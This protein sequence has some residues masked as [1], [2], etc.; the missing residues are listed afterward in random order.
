MLVGKTRR[1]SDNRAPKREIQTSVRRKG[2]TRDRVSTVPTVADG[3]SGVWLEK[4]EMLREHRSPPE[5]KEDARKE[6]SCLAQSRSRCSL[7][8]EWSLGDRQTER[9]K[10][11]KPFYD[12]ERRKKPTYTP[13][14]S[15]DDQ[16]RL[17]NIDAHRVF[18]VFLTNLHI[19][20]IVSQDRQ[21][22]GSSLFGL[23]GQRVDGHSFHMVRSVGERVV[24]E[25]NS[26]DDEDAE[27]GGKDEAGEG[28]ED[29]GSVV[30]TLLFCALR[31]RLLGG[32][33]GQDR[34]GWLRAR[35]EGTA[36]ERLGV[37]RP[38]T[39]H[40]MGSSE[41]GRHVGCSF[42]FH[43]SQRVMHIRFHL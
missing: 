28:P 1:S 42:F 17:L 11:Y 37:Q 30:E 33:F 24:S 9:R 16:P 32:G 35:V 3:K 15:D 22:L 34:A 26:G 13:T 27:D 18:D 25:D 29:D 36:G 41:G 31:L 12:Q 21:I 7:Q 23:E 40:A 20:Q 19:T 39:D 8:V 5:C 2:S 6:N 43:L 10:A 4:K 38:G 14:T